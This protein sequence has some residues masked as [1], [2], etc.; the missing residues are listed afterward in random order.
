MIGGH[1]IAFSCA[2]LE[3]FIIGYI[4]FLPKTVSQAVLIGISVLIAGW[5]MVLTQL[6]HPPAAATTLLFFGIERQGY[7]VFNLFPLRAM[8]SFLAGLVL[9]SVITFYV[10]KK[11]FP[12]EEQIPE[13]EEPCN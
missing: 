2:F 10:Q 8:L 1:L 5:L 13:A 12:K 4:S 9:V 7:L 6:E 11:I 3:P